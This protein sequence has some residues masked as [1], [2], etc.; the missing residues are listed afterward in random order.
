MAEDF[1]RIADDINR[2]RKEGEQQDLKW[3]DEQ[4]KAFQEEEEAGLLSRAGPYI[5]YD[6]RCGFAGGR[7]AFVVNPFINNSLDV[8]VRTKWRD[9]TQSGQ[10]D[11]VVFVPAGGRRYVG[12]TRGNGVGA[13]HYEYSVRGW[14]SA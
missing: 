1:Q 10:S 4:S 2:F 14:T 9:G 13:P 11:D 5:D 12:C 6:G 7:K 3:T 8:T